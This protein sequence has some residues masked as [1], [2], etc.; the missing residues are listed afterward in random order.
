ML[1]RERLLEGVGG[2]ELAPLAGLLGVAEM[3]G[4]LCDAEIAADPARIEWLLRH[5]AQA[6][7][8]VPGM[9]TPVGAAC[10]RG[11]GGIDALQALFASGASPAGRGGFA[12]WLAACMANAQDPRAQR[13]ALGLTPAPSPDVVVVLFLLFFFLF[14]LS[15]S[16]FIMHALV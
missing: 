1:L 9:A 8:R 11:A 15:F 5:G 3:N 13:F 7:A 4:L 10:A 2:D 6:E 14:S 16:T 12:T